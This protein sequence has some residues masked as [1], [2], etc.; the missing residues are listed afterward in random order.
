MSLS[1]LQYLCTHTASMSYQQ[2]KNWSAKDGA[3]YNGQGS[4]IRDPGQYFS[5]VAE[6]K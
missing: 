4:Q 2:G 1:T 6:N 3:Y 5:A